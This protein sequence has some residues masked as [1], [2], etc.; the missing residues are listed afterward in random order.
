MQ[1]IQGQEEEIE[2]VSNEEFVEHVFEL[3]LG[4]DAYSK[5]YTFEE[6]YSMLEDM[7]KVYAEYQENKENS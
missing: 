4:V 6:V 3:C 5:G 7:N 2:I 1:P